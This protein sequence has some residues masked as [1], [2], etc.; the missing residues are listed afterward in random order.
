[1][2]I[3]NLSTSSIIFPS[4]LQG[5]K[6]TPVHSKLKCSNYWPISL[7][8]GIDQIMCKNKKQKKKRALYT[9]LSFEKDKNIQP[10]MD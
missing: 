9:V 3:V 8:S 6:A 5:S 4:I 1:M 2:S 10:P 7:L